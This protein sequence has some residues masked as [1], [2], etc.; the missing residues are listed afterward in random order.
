VFHVQ[1]MFAL[2]LALLFPFGEFVFEILAILVGERIHQGLKTRG[3]W[4]FV[5]T[6]TPFILF[7]NVSTAMLQVFLLGWH[8]ATVANMASLVL[9]FRAFLP[10]LVVVAT[11]GVVA[12]IQRRSL[13]H[14][15]KA[16]ERKTSG[17]NEVAQATVKYMESE[18]AIKRLV[19]EHQ[20]LRDMRA[21]KDE[22]A[23]KFHEMMMKALDEKMDR[24]RDLEDRDR[25]GRNGRGF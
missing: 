22:A 1:G 10:L 7:A 6:F 21:K 5:L 24:L 8:N 4:T 17:I 25:N 14:M 15:I 11:I 19:D 2:A 20:E 9:W 12:G 3:D 16:I 13:S 18:V 23:A